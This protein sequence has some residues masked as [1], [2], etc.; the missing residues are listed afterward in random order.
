M[1]LWIMFLFCPSVNPFFVVLLSLCSSYIK[2]NVYSS[3]HAWRNQI[4]TYIHLPTVFWFSK[5]SN[6]LFLAYSQP[7][8]LKS[9]D[10]LQNA[11]KISQ[12]LGVLRRVRRHLTVDTTKML[13]NS[14][15]L[16][17][18]DYSD[19]VICNLNKTNLRRLQKLQNGGAHIILK[20]DIRT[21]INDMISDLK[22]LTI[23]QRHKLHTSVMI[24]KVMT[25]LA[26]NYLCKYLTELSDRNITHGNIKGVLEIPKNIPVQ[27][28]KAVEWDPHHVC[29]ANSLNTF[30]KLYSATAV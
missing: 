25:I 30:C 13:Y 19:V 9:L 17:L 12:R 11:G 14:L 2:H 28:N 22:W 10:H 1:I 6:Q 15:L 16:P 3:A 5:I 8:V 29:E 4:I 20:A 7:H 26:A 27:R 23:E 18:F 21:H 24:H